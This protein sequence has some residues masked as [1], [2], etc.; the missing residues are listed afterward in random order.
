MSVTKIEAGKTRVGWIGTGVM[1]S[2][3]VGHLMKAGFASTVYNRSKSKAE[4]LLAAGAKWGETPK[5]VAE[6]SDVVFAIVGFPNDV[7]E[8]FLGEQGALAGAKAGTIFVDMTTSDPSLAV[9]IAEAAKAKGCHSVDAPVSGGDVGAKNAAL[10]IMVGGDKSVVEALDPCFKAMG[11]TIIHQGGPGAGQHTKMVNQILVRTRMSA[12]IEALELHESMAFTA[13]FEESS[14]RLVVIVTFLALLELIRI[15]VVRVFQSE[16]FGA[17]LVS[18]A[19]SAV[20]E[21]ELVEESEW[22]NL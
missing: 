10:S 15:R 16:T 6:N 5:A 2:S 21:G 4:A 18:R 9:E 22:K 13:L 19:F 7:R 14:H 17:I 12:I 1:G 20:A 3:M 11:K 8:V